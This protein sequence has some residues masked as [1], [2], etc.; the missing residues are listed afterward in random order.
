MRYDDASQTAST[1]HEP[2]ARPDVETLPSGS[3]GPA[4]GNAITGAG[5]SSGASGADSAAGRSHRRRARSWRPGRAC[6]RRLSGDRPIWRPLDGYAGQ[7]QL[8]PQSRHS[9][10][11]QR[12]LQ[13]HARGCERREFIDDADDGHCPGWQLLLLARTSSTCQPASK[14]PT[15]TST[16]ATSSSTCPTARKW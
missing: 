11:R 13:L 6:Q 9:R 15:S 3:F 1:G 4:S 8:R 7:L 5:T 12:R 16:G 2:V 14:C 10:R